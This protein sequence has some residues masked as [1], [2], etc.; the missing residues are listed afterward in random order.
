MK[1]DPKSSHSSARDRTFL[2]TISVLFGSGDAHLQ[3]FCG[4]W[5]VP[6]S[7]ISSVHLG[8]HCGVQSCGVNACG[9]RCSALAVKPHSHIHFLKSTRIRNYIHHIA[10]I[11]NLSAFA[12]DYS[13]Q[14]RAT[15][16]CNKSLGN[17]K[18]S[19]VQKLQKIFVPACELHFSL[20]WVLAVSPW[21]KDIVFLPHFVGGCQILFS[22]FFKIK[23]GKLS[24]QQHVKIHGKT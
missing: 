12:R 1:E 2:W 23:S 13:S 3:T 24:S 21:C 17:L 11:F 9:W 8:K 6:P 15:D 7:C 20:W 19:S 10:S 22:Q 4:N 14:L 16:K 18:S 5:Q